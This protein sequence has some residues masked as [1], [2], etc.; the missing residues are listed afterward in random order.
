MTAK[1]TTAPLPERRYLTREE[2]SRWLGL[3]I[4][5]FDRLAVPYCDLGPRCRRWDI[6][7]II[8]HA[9][10]NKRCDSARTSAPDTQRRRQ[11][12][13]STNEKAHEHGGSIGE[14]RM[15][16]DTARALG[17]KIKA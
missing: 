6:L 10:E 4:E 16:E 12:C 13:N 3:S 9:N 8:A 17:L 7:D 2:A 15:V 5:S 11:Q 1:A 14:T